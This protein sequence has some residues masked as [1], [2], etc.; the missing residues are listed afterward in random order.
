M[1][2]INSADVKSIRD[3][4]KAEFPGVKFSVRKQHFSSV[5]VTLLKGDVDFSD[6]TDDNGYAQIN[7]Y[8][9][10]FTGDHK[11][12]FE[13]IVEIIKTAP[14]E[15][16]YDRSDA[17][18]D[19]FDTAFY[20]NISVGNYGK[21]YELTAAGQEKTLKITVPEGVNI[22]A[23]KKVASKEVETLEALVGDDMA[24]KLRELGMIK[25]VV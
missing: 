18:Y 1:A 16:W 5:N 22:D 25:E 3:S 21:P 24:A 23:A 2:Y 10:D 19:H 7:Q 9:L 11:P 8:H 4:L 14:A 12:M 17:M 15:G 20:F 6:I 13:K